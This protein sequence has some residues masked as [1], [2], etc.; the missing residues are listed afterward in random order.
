VAV[1]GSGTE[2]LGDG[3]SG[4]TG[5]DHRRRPGA[6]V[7]GAHERLTDEHGV[8][9]LLGVGG[10]VAGVGLI[11]GTITG[12]MAIGIKNDVTSRCDAD[13]KCH[14]ETPNLWSDIDRGV[15]MGNIATGAFIVA[16]IGAGIL[17]YGL[18]NPQRAEPAAGKIRILPS[19]FGVAGTF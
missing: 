6:R 7:A 15:L 17:V 12:L 14:E 9:A 4:R 13:G 5:R 8:G 10:G 2:V 19:P 11:V 3:G 1:V 18:L 16:G